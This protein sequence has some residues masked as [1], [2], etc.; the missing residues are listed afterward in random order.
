MQNAEIIMQTAFTRN[1]IRE[2]NQ[3]GAER[4]RIKKNALLI[5]HGLFAQP[6]AWRYI[7]IY[8][9]SAAAAANT[10]FAGN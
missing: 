6:G 8:S 4:K 5:I 1:N 10:R 7:W 3:V 9:L 2:R